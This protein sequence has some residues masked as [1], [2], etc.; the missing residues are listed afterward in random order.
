MVSELWPLLTKGGFSH[1]NLR[2][3]P[4]EE[5]LHAVEK[6]LGVNASLRGQGSGTINLE[7]EMHPICMVTNG[8]LT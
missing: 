6:I 7:S 8:V 5:Q 2:L 4:L 3:L 1:A